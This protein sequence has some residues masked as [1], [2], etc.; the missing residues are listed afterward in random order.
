MRIGTDVEDALGFLRS[1]P[2][3]AEL[4]VAASLD[5]R[6]AAID[7]VR[8]ALAPYAGGDGVVMYDNGEWLVTARR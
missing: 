6:S 1:T 7:A 5:E 3:V 4:F 2:R 8:E